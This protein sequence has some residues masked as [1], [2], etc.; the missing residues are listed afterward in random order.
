MAI[1]A[2]EVGDVMTPKVVTEDEE[3][4]VTIISADMEVSG[5]GSVVITK[6]GKPVGII[7]DRDIAIKVIMKNRRP[8]EVKAKEIMS[9]PLITIGPYASIEK[10]C[11]LLAERSIRRLPVI[12]DDKLVGIISV[13]NILTRN[14]A[15]VSKFYPLE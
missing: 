10:A 1:E 14:P 13:R 15:C 12:D 3:T 11:A 8:K 2:L 6:E 7:T 4:P 5:I 9:S